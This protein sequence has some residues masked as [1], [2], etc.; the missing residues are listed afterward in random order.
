MPDK[1]FYFSIGA[2][3]G[4]ILSYYIIRSV[5]T[6]QKTA[7]IKKLSKWQPDWLL[8]FPILIFLVGLWGL[9]PD[10]LHAL[11]IFPKEVTRSEIFNVFFMHSYFE[12]IEDIYP[13]IDRL[14]NWTGEVSLFSIAIGTMCY[15]ISLVKKA[16]NSRK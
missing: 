10:I 2:L 16:V 4:T 5:N 11:K 15:Y 8:Y 13:T 6:L 12:K 3:S 9:I 7:L 14:L 1:H